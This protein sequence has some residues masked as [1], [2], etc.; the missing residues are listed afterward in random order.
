MKIWQPQ[1]YLDFLLKSQR[2]FFFK[3]HPHPIVG[4]PPHR[5]LLPL[6]LS[7]SP[8]FL[9]PSLPP[10]CALTL[11]DLK[12]NQ[13]TSSLCREILRLLLRPEPLRCQEISCV[14]E[15]E[16]RKPENKQKTLN[17]QSNKKQ[18]LLNVSVD[19]YLFKN[20]GFLKCLLTKW[21]SC[22]YWE[23]RE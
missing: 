14:A 18:A 7:F 13:N 23:A 12:S 21:S 8:P 20:S 16:T 11:S 3:P 15:L 10:S 9:L 5:P 1:N 2:D 22:S 4:V 6:S 17:P 19:F